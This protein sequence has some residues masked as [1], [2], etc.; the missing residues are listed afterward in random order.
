MTI[1]ASLLVCLAALIPLMLASALP[2]PTKGKSP[3]STEVI[4]CDGE[5]PNFNDGLQ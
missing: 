1:K 3:P 5:S 4:K 2:Y